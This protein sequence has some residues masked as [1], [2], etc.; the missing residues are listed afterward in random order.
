MAKRSWLRLIAALLVLGS[1][2]ALADGGRFDLPGPKVDVRI[3]RGGKMLPVA[4]VPNLLPGDTIWLHPDLPP[5]QSVRYLMVVAFLRG[6]TNPPPDSWFIRIE[7]WDK[8]VREEGIEVKVPDEAQQALLFLAPV[9]GGDFATLKSAVRGR[10]GIFVRASM[11]LNEAGFEQQRIEKYLASIKQVPPGDS[12]ALQDHSNLLART[13][14][15]KPNDACFKQNVDQQYTC[16]TQTGSQTLLDDG[17]GQ[18]IVAALTT[19]SSSDL[20]GAASGT[21]LMGGGVYSAYVGAVIDLARLLGGLHTAQYQYIPAIA[22]P[23]GEAMNLRLN[24]PP[25]F[26]NPKSVIVIGLPSIQKSVAPPLR[27][28]DV[29]HVTCLVQPRV[30]VPVEGAPLV[31]STSFAHDLVLHLSK[32]PLTKNGRKGLQDLPL[33]PDAYQGGLVLSKA[34]E[35][36]ERRVLPE[37]GP[38]AGPQVVLKSDTT[39]AGT[40]VDAA[41]TGTIRGFWGFDAFEGPTIPLQDRPGADWKVLTGEPLIAGHE[42]H[43]VLSSTGTACLRAITFEGASGR[44]MRAA[45]KPVDPDAEVVRRADLANRIDVSLPLG[46]AAP[47]ALELAIHQWGAAKDAPLTVR[48]YSEPAELAGLTLHAGDRSAL[49]TGKHLEQVR[50]L[51]I[52]DLAFGPVS[53]GGGEALP[54]M[55][56]EA[57]GAPGFKAGERVLGRVTLSDGRVLDLPVTVAPA[58]PQITLKS[59]SV[60]KEKDPAIKLMGKDDLRVDVPITLVL[61]SPGTIPRNEEI[62]VGTVDGTLN[63]KL[64]F[65][66][67][68]L[69]LQDSHTLRV[70][71]DAMKAL[72]GSVF[73]PVR[74]RA[75]EQGMDPGDWIA[76]G[77]LV[78]VPSVTSLVCPSEAAKSCELTG[79]S[80][81]LIDAV[82]QAVSLDQALVD[83]V[84]V[85]EDFSDTT[86]AVPHPGVGPLY[87]T[88]RDDPGALAVLNLPVGLETRPL[89]PMVKAPVAKVVGGA[90]E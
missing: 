2:A 40:P 60:P 56:A 81:F 29:R 51:K 26:H 1:S 3:T 39:M 54:M 13:L 44:E 82:G 88:L 90:T 55:L 89:K 47:G 78:R 37:P 23:E 59:R 25:S 73:G 15:L 63:I 33:Q 74:F 5:T 14:A 10:P 28:T 43:L 71:L 61:K 17:H 66:S 87:L 83:P 36:E 11:D 12:K 84:Q 35:P 53:G 20:I 30:A 42:D 19:G 65:A 32:A 76:L 6:T 41:L 24:T 52:G 16:L 85:P 48:T 57:A 49:L 8:K 58:R 75:V 45:W 31:F 50:Q 77:T 68:A 69:V 86:L 62:E 4:S 67:G 21:A 46:Q 70:T 27:T 18:T 79:S 34:P 64:N 38:P 72:G 9:T 80:L 22:F 7:T